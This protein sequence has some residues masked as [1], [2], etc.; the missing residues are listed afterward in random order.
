MTEPVVRAE[1]TTLAGKTFVITGTH[2]MSRKDLTDLIERHGGRI[3]GSVSRTTDYVVAGEN[4][5]SKLDRARELNVE[6][7][8]QDALLRLAE[9]ILTI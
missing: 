4:P 2:A 3:T 9:Q 7:L 8:D 1:R 5:G 6:V